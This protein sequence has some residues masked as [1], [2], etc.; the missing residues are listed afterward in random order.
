MD[1]FDFGQQ[2]KPSQAPLADR[3]RPRALNEFIGQKHLISSH[4]LLVRAIQADKLGNCIFYGPPG[5]GKTTLASIIAATT[6]GAFEKLN[7]VSSGVGDAKRV[8]EEAR[9]R[10][11]MYGKR[12]YLLLDECHRWNK[13]QS[14]SVLGAME[15]GS[16]IFIGSTTENP[17]FAMTKAIVSRCRIF[18]L[19]ALT[20][21]DIIE[22]LRRAAVEERGLGKMNVSVDEEAFEVFAWGAAGDLRNAMNALELAA[23]TTPTDAEGKIHIDKAAAEQSIQ[24][25]S[26]SVDETLYYDML[27]AFCK[28]LRGSDSDAALYWAF[29]LIEAGCD[30]MIMFRRLWAHASEDVGMADSNAMLVVNAA[31]SAYEHMGIVEGSLPLAHA[32][33]Y[34]CTAPKSNSVVTARDRVQDAVRNRADNRVPEH[35]LNRAAADGHVKPTYKYPHNFGGYCAQQYLPDSL[36]DEVYYT[37]SENGKEAD[38]KRFL[39]YIRKNYYK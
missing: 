20:E 34:V 16:I 25:K 30:P 29:H 26:I 19:K 1:L 6:K 39:E 24:R 38:V 17:F 12:T 11:K 9:T 14:D 7:A 27:S 21:A 23:L 13:A 37:P 22:G 15:D 4:S 2:N 33:I 18:E 35:L 36:K 8:I 32:I 3:M 5:T 28:S 31:C 10:L